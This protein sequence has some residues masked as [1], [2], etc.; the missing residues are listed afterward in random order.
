M[1]WFLVHE[2]ILFRRGSENNPGC[3]VCVPKEQIKDIILQEHENQ[4]HFGAEKVQKQLSMIF[5]F[6]KMKAIC[7]KIVSSCDICQKA[8]ISPYL[9]GPMQ[10]IIPSNV[11]QLVC[12]DFVGPLPKSR[13]GVTQLLVCVDA[14]SKLVTLY[15]LKRATTRAVVE[16]LSRDYFIKIGKPQAVLTDNG[17]QFSS[18]KW[19]QYLMGQGIAWRH[20]SVYFP[21]GNPTERVNREIGRIIRTLCYKQHTKWAYV[22]KDVQGWLNRVVHSGT[23]YTPQ[24]LHFGITPK[25]TILSEVSFPPPSL[26]EERDHQVRIELAYRN[27]KTRA[28]KRQRRHDMRHRVQVFGVGDKVLVRTHHQSSAESAEVKK[29]FLLFKGPATIVKIQGHNSYEV[30]EDATGIN[31]GVHNVYNLKPYKVPPCQL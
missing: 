5:Y 20:T 10:S 13:G 22:L 19:G 30:V 25:N 7:R 15:P 26:L 12:L 24:Y 2:G 16:K 11:N 4:G 29:F 6:P 31:L 18:P 23:N 9:H 14:F 1:K 8:K 3:K 17:T 27:L 28:E 21:Q